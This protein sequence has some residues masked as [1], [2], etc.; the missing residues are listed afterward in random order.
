MTFEESILR[1]KSKWR[2]LKSLEQLGNDSHRVCKP[3]WRGQSQGHCN[4]WPGTV[5]QA[6]AGSS[7]V[8]LL[9]PNVY[10]LNF[11]KFN[12]RQGRPGYR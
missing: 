1:R 3:Q 5:P 11:K 12:V 4:L 8:T 9:H 6:T 2:S 10:G 7:E